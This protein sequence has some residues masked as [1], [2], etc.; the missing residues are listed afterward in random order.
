M[1]VAA[2]MAGYAVAYI[3][4]TLFAVLGDDT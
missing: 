3:G 4:N 1:F 2:L